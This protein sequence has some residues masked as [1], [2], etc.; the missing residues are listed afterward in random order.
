MYPAV[1]QRI[2]ALMWREFTLI[3]RTIVVY[4]AK[5]LQVVVVA[6]VAAT[7]F[8]RTHIHP[9]SPNDGQEIAGFCFFATLVMLFNGIAELSMSVSHSALI[10]PW[11]S[12]QIHS[13][14]NLGHSAHVFD[15]SSVPCLQL[16]FAH[17]QQ[18]WL[19]N[20]CSSI[21]NH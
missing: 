6:L 14:C 4:K 19:A 16:W 20:M 10:S 12:F 7:L 3:K 1:M 11:C 2:K 15:L 5:T 8:L 13:G 9:I 17:V 21:Q 18:S